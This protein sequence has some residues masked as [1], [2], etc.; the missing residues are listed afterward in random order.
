MSAETNVNR[1]RDLKT[2][3]RNDS[4]L[5]ANCTLNY[6]TGSGSDLAV[7]RDSIKRVLERQ[8]ESLATARSLPL[9]VL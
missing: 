1:L 5:N 9:P 2:A 3:K 4:S 6:R 7:A 8:F